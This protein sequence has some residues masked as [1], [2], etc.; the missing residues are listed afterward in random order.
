MYIILAAV[1]TTQIYK[2]FLVFLQP[3]KERKKIVKIFALR[4]S[5]AM[6]RNL[7]QKREKKKNQ[8]HPPHPEQ[9]QI[10]EI[11]FSKWLK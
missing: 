9:M 10:I 8:F 6:S 3:K 2:N 5:V 7:K 11:F 1:Y 4:K